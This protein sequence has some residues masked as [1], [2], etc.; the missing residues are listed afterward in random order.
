MSKTLHLTS[1]IKKMFQTLKKPATCLLLNGPRKEMTAFE[2]EIWNSSQKRVTVD[3]GYDIYKQS[4]NNSPKPPSL[5]FLGDSDSSTYKDFANNNL[6]KSSTEIITA[7]DQDYTDFHKCLNYLFEKEVNQLVF[8][9]SANSL[10]R[11]DHIINQLHVLYEFRKSEVTCVIDS[12]DEIVML[13]A[14]AENTENKVIFEDLNNK[15]SL[16]SLSLSGGKAVTNGLAWDLDDSLSLG[17]Q[18]LQSTSN[19]NVKTSVE[20]KV[21]ESQGLMFH[22]T[23]PKK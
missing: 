15:C 22:C 16:F 21:L 19:Y 6:N 9:L 18:T 7:F 12:G 8:V 14:L 11:F 10:S 5:I 17:F 4:I 20:V 2:T 3:G 13:N 23:I 1:N